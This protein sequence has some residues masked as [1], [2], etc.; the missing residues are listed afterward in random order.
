MNAFSRHGMAMAC[1]LMLCG[2]AIPALAQQDAGDDMDST[3]YSYPVVI[4][5]TRLRQSVADV[6]ASVTII[7][8]DTLRRFGIR[9]IPDALRLVPGMAVSQA[10]GNDFRLNYHGT[11]V[12]APRRMNVLVDGFAI[13][14]AALSRVEW[15]SIPV[16]IDD[17]DRIEVTRGPDSAAYGP[18]SMMSVINIITRN[19]R[20][21][22]R[23][24]VSVGGGSHHAAD[25]DVRMA[26]KLG[27]S[28]HVALSANTDRNSGYDNSSID[29]GAHDSV[30]L[31]RLNLRTRTDFDSATTL[32]LYGSHVTTDRQ[33]S[34]AGDPF[35]KAYPDMVQQ[36]SK[37]GAKWTSTLSASHE[38]QVRASASNM[39]NQEDWPTCW[40]K[41]LLYPTVVDFVAAYPAVG[42]ALAHGGQLQDLLSSMQFSPGDMAK[43]YQFILSKGGMEQV[44]MPN[45]GMT[46]ANFRESRAQVELQ[47]TYVVSDRLRIVS[48]LGLR[49]QESES[50]TYLGG[51]V[52]STVRWLFGHA[53]YRS[54]PAL[55]FNVGGYF[56]SNSLSGNSFSPR[57]AANY[58]L[59]ENQ[60]LRAV[61]S[62]GTRSPD[63]LEWGA[64]WAPAMSQ[65]QS[66]VDGQ[67]SLSAV[68]LMRG[69]PNLREERNTAFELGH[70]LALRS[71]GM[72][73]DTRLFQERLT[74][75]ISTYSTYNQLSPNND[76]S[77]KLAGVESQL[78]WDLA[79]TWS[80]W[81]NYSYLVNYQTSNP[82]EATQWSRH[83]GGLGISHNLDEHWQT[84]LS[85]YWASGDGYREQRYGRTDLTVTHGFK[86]D[87]QSGSVAL[88]LSYLHTPSTSTHLSS[89]RLMVNSYDNRL[90]LYGKVRLSF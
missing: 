6:P 33:I 90:G 88:G 57:V 73:I 7:T 39:T 79:S 21:V 77:L 66:P 49:R 30:R 68:T 46:N 61:V 59:T 53:E 17:I 70:M 76:A 28:T 8:R 10:T 74:Q 58:H 89:S 55:T 16:V 38:M 56:E 42:G 60:T 48:G 72:V 47:D 41:L 29:S 44:L 45:C 83:S 37:L 9:S 65:L 86:L 52:N 11:D 43:I 23:A 2:T 32:D 18:N 67:T 22:E 24:Q 3:A 25:V 26:T 54:T 85:T 63:A 71:L 27:E 69:N 62:R 13:Y 5:P 35:A 12:V 64:N 14:G 19:P 80:G 50:Q 1:L 81:L 34:N 40:P 82:V 87:T 31:R 75:L 78:S 51:R 20:D 84:A 15:V 36:D 4:T